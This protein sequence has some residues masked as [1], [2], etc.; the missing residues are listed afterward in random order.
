MPLEPRR[1]WC[2]RQLWANYEWKHFSP[3]LPPRMV[4]CALW[5]LVGGMSAQHAAHAVLKS[6]RKACQEPKAAPGSFRK[7]VEK[8]K[9]LLRKGRPTPPPLP[10]GA[11]VP[12]LKT[13]EERSRALLREKLS[14]IYTGPQECGKTWRSANSLWHMANGKRPVMNC[15]CRF[16]HG[17][18]VRRQRESVPRSTPRALWACSARGVCPAGSMQHALAAAPSRRPTASSDPGSLP[19]L[20]VASIRPQTCAFRPPFC[21][22]YLQ[23]R[24]IC[25]SSALP[26]AVRSPTN[27]RWL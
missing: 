26:C 2:V 10:R 16:S 7:K 8:K 11:A 20:P 19:E 1:R 6:E 27:V 13:G 12:V 24:G 22:C 25:V 23:R 4:T 17:A 9:Q 5:V 3:P 15:S 21:S 18:L 14:L